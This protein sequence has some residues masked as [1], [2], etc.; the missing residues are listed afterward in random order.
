MAR[1]IERLTA[2]KVER[3]KSA[4]QPK[5]GMYHDGGGLY[6]RVTPKGTLSWVLRFM[7]DRKPRYMGLGP[8]SLYGLADARTRALEAKRKRHDGIDPITARRTERARQRLDSAKA[9][10]FKQCAESY[11]ASHKAGWRNAKHKYQWPATLNAYAYPVIG[12]LP[13]QAIDTAL[14]LDVLEP[15]WATKPE[16]ASRVRQRIEN[17]LDFA[18]VR[19]YRDAEA[20][21]LSG[22]GL[23]V[24]CLVE[25]P[26]RTPD[27]H[28]SLLA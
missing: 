21:R 2:Q 20:R 13:V 5:P 3:L 17:I 22:L 27:R 24:F 16:T 11:I 6:L 25:R 18:K 28:P 10:T 26:G 9:V 7:L 4:D 8:V 23:T 15:I 1:A 19:G 14:V 12:A